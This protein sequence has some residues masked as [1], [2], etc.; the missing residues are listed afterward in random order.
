MTGSAM[1]TGPPYGALVDPGFAALIA[2]NRWLRAQLA[3]RRLFDL[4]A[5]VLA[6]QMRMSTSDAA[7]HLTA[8]AQATGLSV[9]DLAADVVNAVAGSDGP[10]DAV[11][12]QYGGTAADQLAEARRA[13][14]TASEAEAASTASE[15]ARTLLRDG[16]S[17]Y[18]ADSLWL[19]QR[20]DHGCLRLAGYAGIGAA[21]AAAWQ[22]IPPGAPGPF[23]AVLAEGVPV[24]LEEGPAR[25]EILPGPSARAARALLP[26]FRRGKQVGLALVGWP[27]PTAFD[28]TLRQAL[29]G[30]LGVGGTVLD[31]AD[32]ARPAVSVPVLVDILDSLT[33]PAA[34]LRVHSTTGTP[35]AD[36]LNDEAVAALGSPHREE[37]A[38]LVR[39]FPLVHVE[40]ARMV[41]RAVSTRRA[42]RAA[43]L[44][45]PAR[46]GEH[47]P[48]LDV[49]VLPVGEER[50]VVLWHNLTD[51]GLATARATARLQS[52]AT[53]QD[54]L[55]GGE[56]SWSEQAYGVFG[57]DRDEPPVPLEAMRG[58]LHRDDGAALTDLLKTLTEHQTGGQAVLRIIL[59]SGAV[60]HV[61]VA[62][63]PLIGE[64]TVTGIVGVYQDVSDSR[65]TEAALTATFDQLTALHQQAETRHQLALQLQRAIVPEVPASLELPGDLTVAVRYRPAT[66]EYR[67][68]GD[69]YD[70]LALP[71]GKI[72]VAVGD[73]A[74][75]GI[76]SV[77]GMVALRNAQRALAFTGDSPRRL[78]GWLNEV[79]LRTGGGTTATAV[80]ALYDPEDGGLLWSSAGHLPM[81]LLRDGRARLLDPPHDVLLGAVPAF[82]YREQRIGLRPGDTLLLYTDGL[83][84][85]RHAGLDEGLARLAAEAERL[86]G[87]EPGRLVDELLSTA[88][89]DTDDDTSLVAVRV[90]GVRRS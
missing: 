81:L 83:I 1:P 53:F 14:R 57:L 19:W 38:P 21:E 28:G 48:L 72:L 50:V 64:G 86:A 82:S 88:T 37:G 17:P 10:A 32:S 89:G 9:G 8:L 43:R 63:E 71:S 42:Q 62:A 26:L 70:V 29:T 84:E 12:T 80:C 68:G 40:L 22:W 18:G 76:D 51:P 65:R 60:R 73:I 56:T 66:E 2:E 15:A 61:R 69:W 13:R 27:G 77:T 78:M 44:P 5:G 46:A 47:A 7:E 36:H 90:G 25:G 52:V 39:F 35:A 49:R 85:R 59:P 23:R 3:H 4:A 34:L 41:R 58:R 24:W 33:H 20:V 30:L 75:H 31:T 16:L 55:A 11:P 79:T 74:G 45:T 6:A 54:S 87:R 67:V